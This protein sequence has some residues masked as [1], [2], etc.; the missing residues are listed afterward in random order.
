MGDLIA[1]AKGKAPVRPGCKDYK[2]LGMNIHLEI[3]AKQIGGILLFK[4][5]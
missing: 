5:T 1:N 2:C 4:Q 3:L